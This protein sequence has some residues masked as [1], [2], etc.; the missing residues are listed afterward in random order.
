M[1]VKQRQG[2][3][4]EEI[5][6]YK[7]DGL[8]VPSYRVPGPALAPLVD[9]LEAVIAA[10]P[11][12]P[13]QRLINVHVKDGKRVRG[14]GAFLEFARSERILD[15]VES[16]L[17]GDIILWNSHLFAKTPQDSREVPWHQDGRYWGAIRPLATVTLW[18]ALNDVDQ[19]NGAVRY[20]PGSHRHGLYTHNA[21][22]DENLVLNHALES[23]L[24]DQ[25]T[26]KINCLEAGQLSLHD[27]FL[28]HGSPAVSSGRRRL[29][30]ALRYMPSTS[31]FDRN[32][33]QSDIVSNFAVMPIFLVRGV[34]RNGANDFQAGH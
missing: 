23:G 12:V 9:A 13:T 8:V 4:E 25:T 27:P 14:H 26:A 11:D 3:T 17:G 34:D 2:L 16:L 29:G 7:R 33:V 10:N 22:K 1:N 24:I 21:V 31:L 6:V 18:L 32:I 15:M 20:I 30:L 19:D 28:V 5:A